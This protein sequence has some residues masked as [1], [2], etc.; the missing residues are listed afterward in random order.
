MVTLSSADTLTNKTL[1]S[2]V[3]STITTN[4]N[5]LTLPT[6]GAGTLARTSDNVASATILA[7]ARNIGGVSFNGSADI[8]LPG[9]NTS[10]TQDTSGNA[11]TATA[12][13]TARNIG[14]VSFDGTGK[15]VYVLYNVSG[16]G[17][18]IIAVDMDESGDLNSNDV[19]IKL[20]GLN[21]ETDIL[22][23]DITS[24]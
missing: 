19:L 14:G 7:T 9:V 18:G 24:Y 12:L 10:G 11:A 17:D 1:T 23:T 2:P 16:I 6:D 3:I 20:S 5:T 21:E 8:N 15:D 22:S 4:G 13:E